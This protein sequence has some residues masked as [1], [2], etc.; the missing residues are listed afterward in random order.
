RLWIGGEFIGGLS[1]VCFGFID[2]EVKVG[3]GG[4]A[5]VSCGA[6]F[7]VNSCGVALAD[8]C[9]PGVAVVELEHPYGTISQSSNNVFALILIGAG[10]GN[11]NISRRYH[12][13]SAA[14][15]QI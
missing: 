2:L 1:V 3:T 10:G 7:G 13:G 12:S 9:G 6:Q 14:G 15:R 8:L 4:V 5:G 11:F